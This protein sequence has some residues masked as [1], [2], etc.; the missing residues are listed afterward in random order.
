MQMHLHL[1]HSI[2][3]DSSGCGLY[4]CI[5]PVFYCCQLN[6]TL[7]T[8]NGRHAVTFVLPERQGLRYGLWSALASHAIRI[9]VRLHP[10][11]PALVRFRPSV[12]Q[13]LLILAR[14][15]GAP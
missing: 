1:K 6:S 3:P 14:G 5:P 7:N 15:A 4:V 2:P 9:T 10:K 11:L 12:V 13:S 8:G